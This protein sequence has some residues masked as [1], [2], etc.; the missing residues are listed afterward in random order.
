MKWVRTM[1]RHLAGEGRTI[2]TS[3]HLMSEMAQTADH[4]L[5]IGRG[6]IITAGPIGEVVA[7]ATQVTVRVV[8]P[9]SGSLPSCS[10]PEVP[11]SPPSAGVSWRSRT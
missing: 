9:D 5:V 4:L 7:A 10:P 11:L 8:T 3:S 1:V 2:F 6:R